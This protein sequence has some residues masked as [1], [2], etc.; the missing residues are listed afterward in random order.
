MIFVCSPTCVLEA[1]AKYMMIRGSKIARQR[2]NRLTVEANL[3][4]VRKDASSAVYDA[5][6]TKLLNSQPEYA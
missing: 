4:A 3:L 6:S 2:A 1:V 5:A